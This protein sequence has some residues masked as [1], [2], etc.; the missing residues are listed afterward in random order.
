ML[1]KMSI[2]KNVFPNWHFSTS[3]K[4]FWPLSAIFSKSLE[5][6]ENISGFL[7]KFFGI[8]WR[9]LGII[10]NSAGILRESFLTTPILKIQLYPLLML[11]F[12]Q[13]ALYFVSLNLELQNR[14]YRIGPIAY[15]N[16][17]ISSLSRK[18]EYPALYNK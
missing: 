17:R 11:I 14:C 3:P 7:W 16:Y 10:W 6:F 13:K 15:K 2:T 9:S 12:R 18:F 8:F 4:G 1:S 5:F